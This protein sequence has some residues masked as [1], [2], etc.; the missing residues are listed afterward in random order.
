MALQHHGE[1]ERAADDLAVLDFVATIPLDDVSNDVLALLQLVGYMQMVR[2]RWDVARSTLDGVIAAA[3]RLGQPG[4]LGMAG[5]LRAEVD[6]RTGRWTEA[7]AEAS[8]DVE[9]NAIRREPVAYFG[10]ATLARIEAARGRVESCREHAAP[11]LATGSRIG[12]TLLEAWSASALGLLELGRGDT[13]RALEHLSVV[14][15]DF[16]EAEC[17]DPGPLWW[18]GDLV[19]ALVATGAHDDA[20]RLVRELDAQVQATGRVWGEAIVAHAVVVSSQ[21]PATTSSPRSAELLETLGRHRSSAPARSCCTVRP[22]CDPATA[23][24]PHLCSTTRSTRS[25]GWARRRGSRAP[26]PPSAPRTTIRSRR[27]CRS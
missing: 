9:L 18:Q 14:W 19:E 12:M 15:S 27:S 23:P 11:A 1:S 17:R 3:R 24:A 26:T 16:Q 25:N 13:R 2:E 20:E 7:E 22:D 4:V 21:R 6:F 8:A 10:H 5:S